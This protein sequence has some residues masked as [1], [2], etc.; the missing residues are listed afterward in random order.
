MKK[1]LYWVAAATLTAAA[2][3]AAWPRANDDEDGE[4]S[5]PVAAVD[6]AFVQRLCTT[7]GWHF[8]PAY[9]NGRPGTR[10]VSFFLTTIPDD[11]VRLSSL[12][13]RP[14]DVSEWSGVVLVWRVP[15]G[16]EIDGPLARRNLVGPYLLHGD[17]AMVREVRRALRR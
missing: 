13:R 16:V 1:T 7:Y 5:G 17:P 6:E 10:Y 9:R 4:Y 3:V 2:V 14:A 8:T 12:Q 15:N 11:W